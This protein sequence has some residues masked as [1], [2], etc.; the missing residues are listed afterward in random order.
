MNP[1]TRGRVP[2]IPVRPTLGAWLNRR[3]FISGAYAPPQWMRVLLQGGRA[4]WWVFP[5]LT[6]ASGVTDL[7]RFVVHQDFFIMA[8]LATATQA[9]GNEGSF[10]LIMVEEREAYRFS[11]FGLNQN[12]QLSIA[13]QPGLLRRPHLVRA[14]SALLCR[15]QNLTALANTV[16]V[17]LFGYQK[18]VP[19]A[20]SAA[21]SDDP[22]AAA[23]AEL[24]ST[25]GKVLNT[26]RLAAAPYLV[27][28]PDSESFH[29]A[30][31]IALP[32]ITVGVFSTVVRVVVPP[33]R[34]GVLN[35]IA[36]Q[37]VGGGFVDFSGAIVWQ[38]VRNP[39]PGLQTAERNYENIVAS[40][41]AVANPAQISPIRLYENDVIELVV[42]NNAIVVGMQTI[43]GL[44]GGYFYPRSYDDQF[45]RDRA[46][47]EM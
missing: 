22:T 45:E 37:F 27:P 20:R 19:G 41:G 24:Q 26:A 14:E 34:N 2:G 30:A 33:G 10:R 38:I 4:F 5:D 1:Y 47:N 23:I 7:T 8:V 13:A 29:V 39:G 44:L 32:A 9:G 25:Q 28:P 43:A 17:A 46:A 36:N 31:G 6:L 35:R 12:T 42:N 16:S 40:L 11:T 21:V 15:I 18:D 3:Q